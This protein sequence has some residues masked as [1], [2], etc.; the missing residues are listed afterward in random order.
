MLT[1]EEKD[2]LIWRCKTSWH[3]KYYCYINDWIDNITDSQLDY[4]RI[5]MCRLKW[6]NNV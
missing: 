2:Y 3:K 1:Q 4:F 6:K 5:E